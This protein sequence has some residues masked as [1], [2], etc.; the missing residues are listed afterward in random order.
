M[1]VVTPL[2][3]LAETGLQGLR[4]DGASGTFD[5]DRGQHLL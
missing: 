3:L 4:G 5:A 2:A 1:S